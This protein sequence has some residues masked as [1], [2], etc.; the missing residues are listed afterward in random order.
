LVNGQLN[1]FRSSLRAAL[2]AA[3]TSAAITLIFSH[4]WVGSEPTIAATQTDDVAELVGCIK[5]T[6]EIIKPGSISVEFYEHI[7]RLCGNQTY[8]QLLLTD[9]AIRREKLV[10]QELDERVNLWMVVAITISGVILAAVQ[11]VM[12]YKLAAAGRAEFAKDSGLAAE[13]GK[14]SLRSSVTGVVI[15]AISLAFFGVYVKWIYT[16]DELKMERPENLQQ[17]PL[18]YL[19]S[20]GLSQT[21]SP[22]PSSQ[23]APTQT[24]KADPK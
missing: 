15:L 4:R 20:G 2:I 16:I 7:W 22:P 24:Q 5:N 6:I 23:D 9:F 19:G 3:I 17:P 8:N 1:Q 21:S 11:L 13:Q 18:R 14:I 10:R 12:S